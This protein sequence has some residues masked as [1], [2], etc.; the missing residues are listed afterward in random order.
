MA[1]SSVAPIRPDPSVMVPQYALEVEDLLALARSEK[2]AVK[3]R[4]GK[5]YC[6]L[7]KAN[8]TDM[9]SNSKNSR[10]TVKG[11]G[12]IVGTTDHGHGVIW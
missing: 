1:I 7:L 6:L 10:V 3:Y 2:E 12:F 9:G 11:W 8:V 5:A 4:M